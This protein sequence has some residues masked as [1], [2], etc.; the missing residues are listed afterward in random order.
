MAFD[1]VRAGEVDVEFNAQTGRFNADVSEA[2]RAYHEATDRMSDDAVRLAIA[3]DKLNRAIARYGPESNQAKEAGLRYRTALRAVEDQAKQTD[4]A[5]DRNARSLDRVSREARQADR[6]VRGLRTGFAGL[7]G[8]VLGATAAVGVVG[9]ANAARTALDVA[10]NLNEQTSKART[11]FGSA[12]AAVEDFASNALGLAKD[13]ALEAAGGIGALLRPLGVLEEDAAGVSVKLTKLGVDLSSFY[14]TDVQS[15]LDAIRS[16]LSGESEPLRKYGILLSE[17]RV[18]ARALADTGKT[19]AKELTAQEKTLARVEIILKD[20]GLAAGDYARTIGGV[21][22]QEREAAKNVRN[23]EAAIGQ[24][25]TPAYRKALEVANDWLSNQEN[26]DRVTGAVEDTMDAVAEAARGVYEAFKLIRD[27]TG[28]LIDAMGGLDNAAKTFLILGALAKLR[29]F[30]GGFAG[31]GIQS[32]A[33]RTALAT[34][35]AGM[36]STLGGL[37]GSL[38]ALTRS[39]WTIPVVL[40]I[41]QS[42]AI[43]NAIRDK[44]D[45]DRSTPDWLWNASDLGNAILPGNPFGDDGPAKFAKLTEA[46]KVQAVQMVKTAENARRFF[47]ITAAEYERL[48]ALPSKAPRFDFSSP[49]TPKTSGGDIS[50]LAADSIAGIR[51]GSSPLSVFEGAK[52]VAPESTTAPATAASKRDVAFELAMARATTDEERLKLLV[53]RREFLERAVERFRRRGFGKAELAF[54]N[55]LDDTKGAIQGIFEARAATRAATKAAKDAADEQ[56][57]AEKDA[58]EEAARAEKDA[59]RRGAI[60]LAKIVA[61]GTPTLVDD[62][63]AADR[64]IAYVRELKRKAERGSSAWLELRAEE[65]R[66]EQEKAALEKQRE[67][68][69]KAAGERARARATREQ[70]RRVR[71]AA[72]RLGIRYGGPGAGGPVL[73]ADPS[74]PDAA[75]G[76]GLR[77]FQELRASFFSEFSSDIFTRGDSG[78]A[79]GSKPLVQHLHFHREKDMLAAAREARDAVAHAWASA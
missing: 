25:L 32:A 10:S 7:R 54:R 51:A 74:K 35:V 45:P 50:K 6:E 3:Q 23:L 57:K 21:A 53:H 67:A 30:V 14:N 12:S 66:L 13:Q 19:V 42:G 16:G 76:L 69:L 9:F 26:V 41:T 22:N 71:E 38:L 33:A 73:K 47:G 60:A 55:E 75:K 78:L 77:E 64:E 49:F 8:A 20:A 34:N 44:V 18:Q 48:L 5:I 65:A 72:E 68:N 59:R 29:R 46:Q 31:V 62:I 79:P 36:T 11:V 39:P 28:P 2:R 56:A 61:A 24:A 58:R 27:V 1:R 4:T 70:A 17:A 40:A 15:A 63:K 43:T 37:Q 52:P